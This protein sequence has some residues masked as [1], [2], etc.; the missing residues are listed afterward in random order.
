MITLTNECNIQ[1]MARYPD[2]HFDL[3]IVDPSYGIGA[4]I[5][6]NKATNY[7]FKHRKNDTWDNKPLSIEYFDELFRVSKKQIIW[8]ANHFSSLLLSNPHFCIWDKKKVV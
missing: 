2:K 8:G 3:A 6:T 5:G 7:K 1:L 4:H